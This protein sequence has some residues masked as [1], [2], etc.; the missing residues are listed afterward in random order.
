MQH[1]RREWDMASVEEA[2]YLPAEAAP[3]PMYQRGSIK[4]AV[5]KRGVG[6]EILY[7]FRGFTTS[8]HSCS[9]GGA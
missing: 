9:M 7:Y 3:R 2:R 6:R 1:G 4:R 8:D 5:G